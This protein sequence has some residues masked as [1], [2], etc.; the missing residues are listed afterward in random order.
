MEWYETQAGLVDEE[1]WKRRIL[2]LCREKIRFNNAENE[3]S[4]RLFSALKKRLP[5]SPFGVMF[6]GGVDSTLIAFAAKKLGAEPICFSVGMKNSE[7]L[8]WASLAAG[9]LGF[10]LEKKVFSQEEFEDAIREVKAILRTDDS[11]TLSIGAVIYSALKLAKSKGVNILFSGLG[12]E[13]IFAGYDRHLKALKSGADVNE[14]CRKGLLSMYKRDLLRDYPI[15]RALSC[16][17]RTPFLD[18]DVIRLAMSMP[19][20]LKISET[21]KKIILRK[22]AVFLGLPERFA[23]RKKRAAQ[24]G[25]GFDR[26]LRR[27][28]KRHGFSFRKD[29]VKNLP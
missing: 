17:I 6:S 19:S 18:E 27:A 11:V 5:D 12:S 16:E 22:A 28:A 10:Q 13:E 1:G 25:S 23:M 24:Y 21:E 20:S 8:R 29:Y 15:A 3:L 7:D 2:E 4:D 14:E 9:E 26:E